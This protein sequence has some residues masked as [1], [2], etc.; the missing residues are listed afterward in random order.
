MV[1]MKKWA[2]GGGGSENKLGYTVATKYFSI[3]SPIYSPPLVIP[4]AS[5]RVVIQFPR[6]ATTD[7]PL[8]ELTTSDTEI[9]DTGARSI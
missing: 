8:T 2:G 3:S 9:A 5:P 4:A 1:I 7:L 6:I